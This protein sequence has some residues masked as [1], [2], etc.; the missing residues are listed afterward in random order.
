MI[1]HSKKNIVSRIVLVILAGACLNACREPKAVSVQHEVDAWTASWIGAPW[2]GEVFD[3]AKVYPAPEFSKTL[4]LTKKVRSAV[5]SVTGLGFFEFYVNGIKCGEDVLSPNET[6]YG[7][8]ANLIQREFD[9][10]DS[11]WR[12]FRVLYLSYD[13]TDLLKRGTNEFSALVGNGFYAIRMNS[14]DA[15][16]T[17]RF[18]CQVD[19]TYSD[20]TMERVVSDEGWKVR[21]SPIVMN[22]MY[23]GEIYDARLEDSQEWQS[24]VLRKAPDGKLMLQDGVPDRVVR[25]IKPSTVRQLDDSRWEL[26]F[27]EYVTG[28][29]RLCNFQAEEGSEIEIDFPVETDGNGVY[30]YISNG[31]EVD[32]YAPRFHWWAYDRAIISGWPGELKASNIVAEVVNSDVKEN[33]HFS[34]SNTLFNRICEIW[35]QSMLDNMH[36]GVETDCPHREKGPYTGDGE[37]SCVAVLHNYDV[38]AFYRKW[39]RDMSDCQD[40]LSGYVPNATPWHPGCG[41]GVPWGAAMN[42]MPWEHYLR[43][44]LKKVLEENYFPMKEQLRYMLG[45]RLEDGTMFQQRTR[46]DGSVGYW[47]NLGDWCPPYSLP[48]GN[49]VHTWYLWR[50][51]SYTAKAAKALGH[52]DD[53]A[54]YQALSD[55]VAAAFHVK[56]YNPETG[57]YGESGPRKGTGYGVGDHEGCGDGSNIYA[58]AMGV[59]AERYDRVI[60]AVKKELAANDGH[61]NTGIYASGLFFEVLCENGLAEAA[62]EAMNKTDYPSFGHWI[63]QGAKTMWEQWNGEGSRVHHMF[64]G[65]VTWLYRC[66]CGVQLD[67][68]APA[69]KHIIL[70]PKPCGDIMWAEYSTE[71]PFG[72]LSV[73]WKRN[74]EGRFIYKL[75][76]PSGSYATVYM[77]DGST[78]QTVHPGRTTLKCSCKQL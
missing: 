49:L 58:L 21:R 15:Y 66:L 53:Y 30:K 33:A 48:S 67:E 29:L 44:G 4:E 5:A 26:V 47:M 1:M 63:S 68:E 70:Q 11:S 27:D 25:T 65:A 78:P 61:F 6:S 38:S 31:K 24:V 41:G 39:F 57:S 12:G 62:F 59:P 7:H 75:N 76:I 14:T 50:C 69:Y 64:G 45:W 37:A 35:K 77:P 10:D 43:Y 73:K 2:D 36:L 60:E 28:W 23:E 46:T 72:L 52:M 3:D 32:S 74:S 8:R 56:F 40:S 42:I 13:I 51:A 34:C 17:P 19:I 54:T 22:D 71:T 55:S 18:I 9:M 16:G 20:G